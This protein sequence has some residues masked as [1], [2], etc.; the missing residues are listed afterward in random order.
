MGVSGSSG[1]CGLLTLK[2]QRWKKFLNP[3]TGTIKSQKNT[4]C[5]LRIERQEFYLALFHISDKTKQPDYSQLLNQLWIYAS[6][7]S[8]YSLCKMSKPGG[9]GTR[10]NEINFYKD[11]TNLNLMRDCITKQCIAPTVFRN[12]LGS[13]NCVVCPWLYLPLDILQMRV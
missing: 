13:F 1:S 9:C 6:F 4:R 7:T 11:M 8:N 10:S 3:K 12:M 2:V 5:L